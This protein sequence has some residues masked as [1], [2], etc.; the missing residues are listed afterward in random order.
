VI[1]CALPYEM[2]SAGSSVWAT[3]ESVCRRP[4]DYYISFI[5]RVRSFGVSAWMAGLQSQRK[6]L[7]IGAWDHDTLLIGGLVGHWQFEYL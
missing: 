4:D 6:D 3:W 7:E 1:A 2:R 5:N